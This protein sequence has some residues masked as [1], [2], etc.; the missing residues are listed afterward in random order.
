M[1]TLKTLCASG[2]LLG[3]SLFSATSAEAQKGKW[4]KTTKQEVKAEKQEVKAEQKAVKQQEKWENKSQK[5]Y[6][7]KATP[8]RTTYEPKTTPRRTISSRGRVLCADGIWVRRTSNACAN[9]GGFAARQ[10]TYNT[11]NTPR[12]SDRAR[13]RAALN[14]AVRRGSY[15]NLTR[16]NAIA[17]CMDGTYWHATTRTGACYRHGGVARWY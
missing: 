7:P 10:G 8:K 15:S 16:A 12:A 9:R 5:P 2:L 6:E 1:T 14:S 17:R 4:D 11:N 13:E 3:A